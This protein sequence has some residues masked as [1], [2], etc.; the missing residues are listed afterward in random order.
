MIRTHARGFITGALC[1]VLMTCLAVTSQS[2]SITFIGST[3]SSDYS[4]AGLDLGNAGFWFAN[5]NATAPQSGQAIDANAANS[6]PAWVTIDPTPDTTFSS[7]ATTSGGQPNWATLTLP[8][9]TTGLSGAVV[10][11]N[12]NNNS[13]NIIR[14]LPLG[15]GTPSSF[16]FHVVT[17]NTAGQHDPAGRLRARGER[18]GIFDISGPNT[19]PGLGDNMNGSPDVYT[20][21]YEGFASG[22]IIKLQINSANA[23]EFASI[24]GIMFDPIPE[25]SSVLLLMLGAVGYGCVARRVRR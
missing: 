11:S 24:S 4:D 22:D 2:Q 13:N 6:L 12:T 14:Q 17:D 3:N 9:G 20:W 16:F 15:P 5:F 1:L 21:L 8:D 18:D 10:D 25:P 19:P 23:F 7:S